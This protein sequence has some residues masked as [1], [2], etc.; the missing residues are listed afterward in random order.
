MWK[1][2]QEVLVSLVGLLSGGLVCWFGLG[3][4]IGLVWVCLLV[5]GGCLAGWF[6][7]TSAASSLFFQCDR[8]H[9]ISNDPKSHFLLQS[10]AKPV[11]F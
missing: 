7:V 1:E 9:M 8:A 6:G 10:I 4:L 5:G 2:T 11:D 3:W